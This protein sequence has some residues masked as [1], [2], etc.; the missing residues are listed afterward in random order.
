M[1]VGRVGVELI[2]GLRV[3]LVYGKFCF[4]VELG[5]FWFFRFRI[6]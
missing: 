3:F 6:G 5:V 2:L 1:G 4:K